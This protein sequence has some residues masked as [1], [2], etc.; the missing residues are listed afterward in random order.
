MSSRRNDGGSVAAVI[1]EG[2]D[3]SAMDISP[4]AKPQQPPQPPLSLSSILSS[5]MASFAPLIAGAAGGTASTVL[6]LPLDNIKVRLQVNEGSNGNGTSNNAFVSTAAK[7]RQTPKTS[8]S[9]QSAHPH[10]IHHKGRQRLGS[11]T[12]LR[13]ILRY[14]GI[15]GLYQGLVPAVIGN[16]AS[17]GGFFFIYETLKHRMRRYKSEKEG[18]LDQQEQQQQSQPLSSWE[19]FQV[20]TV[21]GMALV[22]MTNPIWLIKIRMQLQ[23]KHASEQLMHETTAT[24]AAA[25]S[26]TATKTTTQTG[27]NV[28][29]Y[30][31][32]IDAI[33]TIIKEEGFWALYKGTGPA[34]LLTSHG[35]VQFVVYEF[36]RKHFHYARAQRTVTTETGSK[37]NSQVG[38]GIVHASVWYRFENSFGYLMMGAASKM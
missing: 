2:T 5:K 26:A 24:A 19:N 34:L 11:I 4:H 28:T 12:V 36:L 3:K 6:L 29:Q 30:N 10:E 9:Q 32:F 14:E 31:G 18:R 33:R 15:G 1:A 23:M 17:W 27:V 35:G 20:A 13:G 37:N 22:F 7:Q 38:G 25:A 16:A 21:S 8:S